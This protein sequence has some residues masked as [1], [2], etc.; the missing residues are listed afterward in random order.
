MVYIYNLFVVCSHKRVGSHAYTVTTG[1]KESYAVMFDQK[2]N[3]LVSESN[4]TMV[5]P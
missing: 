4:D 5:C 3:I 2:Q 1:I